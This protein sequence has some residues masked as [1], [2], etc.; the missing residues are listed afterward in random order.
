MQPMLK[1]ITGRNLSKLAF[2]DDNFFA[3]RW[4]LAFPGLFE[5]NLHGVYASIKVELS[6]VFLIM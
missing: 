4:Y 6:S 1:D 2:G 5:G 3:T